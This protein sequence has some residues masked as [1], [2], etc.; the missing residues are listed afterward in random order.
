MTDNKS[1][2]FPVTD[3]TG[4]I[5]GSVTRGEAHG[6]SRVLHPVVHLHVFN[7]RGEL[8]LQQRPLWKDI[9]PGRWDTAVGGHVNYSECLDDNG[10]PQEFLGESVMKA[11]RREAHEE[12][13][14]S[15]FTPEFLTT[16]VFEG[17]REREQVFSFYTVFDGIVLPSCDELAGGRFWTREEIASSLGKDIFTPN[18]EDEYVKSLKNLDFSKDTMAYIHSQSPYDSRLS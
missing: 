5:L 17:A 11:L 12:L 18:F 4:R 8:Y 15:G 13:G 6:G 10:E 2:M 1:E 14:I 7:S 3:E 9:Q 16:Y